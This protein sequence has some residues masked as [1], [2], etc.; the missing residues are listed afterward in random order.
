MRIVASPDMR[1]DEPLPATCT[2]RSETRYASE[3]S[4]Q[5]R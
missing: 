5:P 4:D 3:G 1:P 2:A